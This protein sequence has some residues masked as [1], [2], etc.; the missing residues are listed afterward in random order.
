MSVI[1]ITSRHG[2]EDSMSDKE[3]IAELEAQVEFLERRHA[4][5]LESFKKQIRGI[6]RGNPQHWIRTALD[7]V[8]VGADT[9]VEERLNNLLDLF[10]NE[11]K[12]FK[13]RG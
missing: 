12:W 13:K 11:D 10:T 1:R 6:L 3:R 2:K 8:R 7:A 4:Y 9:A 5:E